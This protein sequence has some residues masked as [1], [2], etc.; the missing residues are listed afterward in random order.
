M[1]W[2]PPSDT[3]QFRDGMWQPRTI[4]DVSYPEGGNDVCF[5][6]EDSSYWFNH[7]NSCILDV[8]QLFPPQGMI[9]DIG[10]GNGFV[11]AA[12]Q[13]AGFEVSLV[14]PGCGALNAK[15]RGV[16]NVIHAALQDTGFQPGSLHAT[17]AFDVVEHVEDDREF[18]RSLRNL[19]KPGG[20]LYLSVPASQALWSD[21]DVYAGHFR[22]Y[23]RKSLARLLGDADLEIEFISGFFTWL[24]LPLYLLRALPYR[25]R[26]SHTKTLGSL[27]I[28]QETHTLPR[29]IESAIGKIHRWERTRLRR[30][31]PM[32]LGS[33][34]IC[35]A[36]AAQR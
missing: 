14:E 1:N 9:Y 22:R 8:I 32:S 7:R 17:C 3:L 2:V 15:K 31:R 28:T 4:S 34:L 21:Q 29:L 6:V 25:L 30:N 27:K 16:R 36:R 11:A 5:Q 19:L 18:V 13:E 24:V 20:R 33:S 26:G 10:G 35:C 12:L 23:S